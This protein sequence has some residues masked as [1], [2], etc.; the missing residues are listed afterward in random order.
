MIAAQLNR[1]QLIPGIGRVIVEKKQ[2]SP[3]KLGST[4]LLAAALGGQVL[5]KRYQSIYSE[6]YQSVVAAHRPHG[7]FITHYG[8]EK[9]HQRS[10][11][12]FSGQALLAVA[13][14][15]SRGDIVARE[16][17]FAAFNPY[18]EQFL[19]RPT[20]AFVGWH[21]DVWTRLA[22]LTGREDFA[23]FVFDQADWLL[24]LQKTDCNISEWLGG[25]SKNNEPPNFSSIVYLEALARAYSMARSIK[26]YSRVE[27]YR[28]AVLS[29][30]QFCSQLRLESTPATWFPNPLRCRGGIGLGLLDR[31]VRCDIPQHFI[32]LCVAV[33]EHPDLLL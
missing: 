21:I 20:T 2:S 14:A 12:F 5:K 1:S 4:A 28:V 27:K 10:A 30:L 24:R 29:G 7:R 3:P 32:T 23:R 8:V 9:E 31:R 15:A 25:F 16:I 26:D 17:C 18:R 6:L 13:V 33:L 11:E 22:I 19:A